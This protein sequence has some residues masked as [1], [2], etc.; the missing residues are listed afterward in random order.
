MFPRRTCWRWRT[1]HFGPGVFLP[2]LTAK[3]YLAYHVVPSWLII[4]SVWESVTFFKRCG[5]TFRSAEPTVQL[6]FP[7]PDNDFA[8][9]DEE[10]LGQYSTFLLF[11]AEGQVEK[12]DFHFFH[13][14]DLIFLY[15][16]FTPNFRINQ[17]LDVIKG[18]QEWKFAHLKN[19]RY[20]IG[21]KWERMSSL[22]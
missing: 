2:K 12:V 4:S 14:M 18:F 1:S 21:N 3:R 20:N 10:R 15:L 22:K 11:K 7:R 16:Y 5:G 13:L 17:I 8:V 6:L 19:L 9:M